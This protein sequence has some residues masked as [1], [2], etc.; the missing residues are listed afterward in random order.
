MTPIKPNEYL[1]IGNTFQ[2]T[3]FGNV[4][5]YS[6]LTIGKIYTFDEL[7][8]YITIGDIGDDTAIYIKDDSNNYS[9]Y[10]REIFKSLIDIRED[11]INKLFDNK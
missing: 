3:I 7:P 6:S 1:C 9:W 4:S 8:S 5:I 11:K 2:K 10:P